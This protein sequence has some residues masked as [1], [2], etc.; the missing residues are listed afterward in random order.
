M[1]NQIKTSGSKVIDITDRFKLIY[2][3]PGIMLFIN[4]HLNAY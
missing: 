3:I 2:K 1:L 4:I